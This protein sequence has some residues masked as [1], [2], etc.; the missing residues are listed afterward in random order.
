MRLLLWRS[1]AYR[2]I[3]SIARIRCCIRL[4]AAAV[5]VWLNNIIFPI[6]ILITHHLNLR[7][8]ATVIYNEHSDVLHFI[9]AG[10][11]FQRNGMH[12]ILNLIIYRDI[13]DIIVAIKIEVIDLVIGIVQLLFK[14]LQR[15]R[16]LEYL[17]Y[18]VKIQIIAWQPQGF[19]LPR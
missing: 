14:L 12:I 10:G 5:I 19:N 15:C 13:I 18:S 8:A 2:C 16:L 17:Q 11:H 4:I 3:S 1:V 7:L 6:K 9:F